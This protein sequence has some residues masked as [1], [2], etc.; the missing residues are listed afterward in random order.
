MPFSLC[1]WETVTSYIKPK[2]QLSMSHVPNEYLSKLLGAK[3]PFQSRKY[4]ISQQINEISSILMQSVTWI[5]LLL[6]KKVWGSLE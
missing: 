6:E 3:Y 1:L 4:G 5:N 2:S